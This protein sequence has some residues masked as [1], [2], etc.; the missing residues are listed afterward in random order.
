MN[1]VYLT[2]FGAIKVRK[3][4]MNVYI[5]RV[6]DRDGILYWNIYVYIFICTYVLCRYI[7]CVFAL[8]EYSWLVT[9]KIF[10]IYVYIYLINIFPVRLSG[11]YN[12]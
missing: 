4:N 6:I 1:F 7:Y 5:Q 12:I 10:V 9:T 3:K 2:T 8:V 11:V